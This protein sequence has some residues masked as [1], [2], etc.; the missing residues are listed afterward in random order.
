MVP[1][2]NGCAV[3][4]PY[5]MYLPPTQNKVV[6]ED[7]SGSS[8]GSESKSVIRIRHLAVIAPLPG[9]PAEKAGV[10]AG[11]YIVH[12]TDTQRNRYRFGKFGFIDRSR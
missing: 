3:G 10:K 4:D 8:K 9:S 11:D 5:T 6:N 12:I 2:R 7:L 1:F